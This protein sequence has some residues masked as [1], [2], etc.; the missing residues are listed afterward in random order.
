MHFCTNLPIILVGCKT[1]DMILV[2]EELRKMN[3]RPVTPKVVCY[4]WYYQCHF[5]R[6][7]HSRRCALPNNSLEWLL[8]HDQV[9]P[10]AVTLP[11]Q[12]NRWRT[13]IYLF[14]SSVLVKPWPQNAT[15]VV[16]GSI[17]IH[18]MFLMKIVC[19]PTPR[20]R[21]NRPRDQLHI[22]IC[23][24]S[25]SAMQPQSS[26]FCWATR[27]F[28][29]ANAVNL[30]A[31]EDDKPNT[32]NKIFIVSK[33]ET[34]LL[35]F[36]KELGWKCQGDTT[37]IV[38]MIPFSSKHKSRVWLSDIGKFCQRIDQAHHSLRGCEL[39]SRH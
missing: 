25:R 29:E 31:F 8:N 14:E 19:E 17:G 16:D 26:S 39:Q 18:A 1:L 35:Q 13:R 12:Q 37:D 32:A 27:P 11:L 20:R 38:Q 36:A 15:T 22:S 10:V 28:H 24:I 23:T 7:C 21:E 34:A 5:S 2:I 3:Q 9:L 4:Q 6:R 33:T 30:M